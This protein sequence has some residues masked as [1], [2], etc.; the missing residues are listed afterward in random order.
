[1]GRFQ[2]RQHG[3]VTLGQLLAQ[4]AEL[5]FQITH[6]G[7]GCLHI[8]EQRLLAAPVCPLGE[9]VARRV[10]DEA[11]IAARVHG[12]RVCV[13]GVAEAFLVAVLQVPGI[14]AALGVQVPHE[15]RHAVVV[16]DPAFEVVPDL[17]LGSVSG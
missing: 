17:R 9:A 7:P 16:Q 5:R 1:M 14:E 13:V 10:P 15:G 12:C 11:R 8:S 6:G 4:K 3:R 2:G